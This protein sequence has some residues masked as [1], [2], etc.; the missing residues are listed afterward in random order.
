[1][2]SEILPEVPYP[3]IGPLL[4]LSAQ[5]L[6]RFALSNNY[7]ERAIGMAAI[8]SLLDPTPPGVLELNAHDWLLKEGNGRKVV[9]VGHFPFVTRLSE[10]ANPL[11]ILEKR[12]RDGDLPAIEAARVIPQADIVAITGS[13][14]VNQSIDDLLALCQP[15]TKV[16][17]LGPSTPLAP[18]L[19]NEGISLLSTTYVIDEAGTLESIRS[20][21]SYYSFNGIKRITLIKPEETT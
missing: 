1:L 13:T 16:V 8:N 12:P 7:H 4:R 17:I 3:E 15:R 5:E 14:F 18:V 9:L 2:W 10:V 6:A 19:F 11:W 20:G 21:R